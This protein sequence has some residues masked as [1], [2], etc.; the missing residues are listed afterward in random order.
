MYLDD[1]LDLIRSK[2]AGKRAESFLCPLLVHIGQHINF[3]KHDLHLIQ[4]F[5]LLGLFWDTVNMS[6]YLPS[7]KL[8][9]I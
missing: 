6:V 7:D 2:W 3:S 5:C 1:I 9:D 4:R 8:A